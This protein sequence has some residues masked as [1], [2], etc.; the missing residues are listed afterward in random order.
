[1]PLRVLHRSDNQLKLLYISYTHTHMFLFLASIETAGYRYLNRAATREPA[2]A[3]GILQR[4]LGVQLYYFTTV[5]I[6]PI[7]IIHDITTL[8]LNNIGIFTI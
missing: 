2:V 4:R 6:I 8:P 3:L 5:S 1:M 7:K